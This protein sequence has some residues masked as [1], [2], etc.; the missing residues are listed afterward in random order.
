[1]KEMNSIMWQEQ[2]ISYSVKGVKE[3]IVPQKDGWKERRTSVV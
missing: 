2:I 1:M 3:E